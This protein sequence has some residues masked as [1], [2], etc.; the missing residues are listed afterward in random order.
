MKDSE[1]LVCNWC[2]AEFCVPIGRGTVRL[3]CTTACRMAAQLKARKDRMSD[4]PNCS[5]EWCHRKAVRTGAGLCDA[6]YCR[7]RRGGSDVSSDSM[8]RKV[9][10]HSA[11]Y[12]LL[13][14]PDHPLAK[15]GTVPE[16]RLVAYEKFGNGPQSCYWC[17]THLEWES[18]RHAFDTVRVDHLNEVKNDN[19]PDNLVISCNACNRLRGSML[20]L[21]QTM[22]PQAIPL[23]LKCVG[24]QLSRHFIG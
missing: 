2:N 6:C 19:H 7:R 14:A 24:E 15:K 20:P 22:R 21:I 17:G 9:K 3:Y 11:G 4:L 16:H 10:N 5:V 23:F 18:D 12:V 8:R 13:Y 1:P